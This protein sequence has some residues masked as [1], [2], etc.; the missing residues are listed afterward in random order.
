MWDY[1]VLAAYLFG[2]ALNIYLVI[3]IWRQRGACWRVGLG[4]ALVIIF[5]GMFTDKL[6]VVRQSSASEVPATQAL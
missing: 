6:K 3:E 1:F 5:A 2:V 4:V